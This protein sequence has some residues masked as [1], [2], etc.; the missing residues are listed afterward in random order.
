VSDQSSG[1][2]GPIDASVEHANRY[3]PFGFWRRRWLGITDPAAAYLR[4]DPRLARP[5]WNERENATQP[6]GNV[7]E[8]V[9]EQHL[10]K[11]I[12]LHGDPVR[13]LP[14]ELQS[15][16]EA[17]SLSL[18][19]GEEISIR[20]SEGS[21]EGRLLRFRRGKAVLELGSLRGKAFSIIRSVVH[22]D[23]EHPLEVI[24]QSLAILLLANPL[25]DVARHVQ[26]GN[27]EPP[28]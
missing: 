25:D 26:E 15:Q 18:I 21:V 13:S 6:A 23:G 10:T 24:R 22:T 2:S 27:F 3:R 28:T 8:I 16:L 4:Q 19:K 9:A 12:K 1:L 7:K 20:T 17:A 5:W 14:P 11:T